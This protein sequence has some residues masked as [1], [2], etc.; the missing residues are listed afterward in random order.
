M[1]RENLSYDSA[2]APDSAMLLCSGEFRLPWCY[3]GGSA[4]DGLGY[5]IRSQAISFGPATRHRRI[6]KLACR[7]HAACAISGGLFTAPLDIAHR[8]WL[9]NSRKQDLRMSTTW[10]DQSSNGPM[11][12]IP[13][14]GEHAKLRKF[15]HTMRH[16]GNC[17]ING[18]TRSSSNI[19]I[20]GTEKEARHLRKRAVHTEDV[21]NCGAS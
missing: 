20:A 14:F 6:G 15:I 12:D 10:R 16:G 9:R 8:R 21:V 19:K 11:K 2:N 1:S 5:P 18:C 7:L 3:L 13:S 4:D 17:W